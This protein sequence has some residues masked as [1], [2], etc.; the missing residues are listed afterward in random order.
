[1]HSHHGFAA[2]ALESADGVDASAGAGASAVAAVTAGRAI[3][4]AVGTDD[5]SLDE[6]ESGAEFTAFGGA[7]AGT[8]LSHSTSHTRRMPT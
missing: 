7:V 6:F 3:G 1:M 8:L 2:G 5:D 4:A